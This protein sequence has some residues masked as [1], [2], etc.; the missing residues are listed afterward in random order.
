MGQQL[1]I[2]LSGKF[3]KFWRND[4][5]GRQVDLVYR[6]FDLQR[7]IY[8][9]L[10]FSATVESKHRHN[11]SSFYSERCNSVAMYLPFFFFNN[12]SRQKTRYINTNGETVHVR[13]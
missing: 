3:G 1:D 10:S 4:T 9:N 2:V 5:A 12:S 7:H 13:G 8:S 6:R 11:S